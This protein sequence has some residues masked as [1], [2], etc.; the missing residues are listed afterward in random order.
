MNRRSFSL[1]SLLGA[2]FAPAAAAAPGSLGQNLPPASSLDPVVPQVDPAYRAYNQAREAIMAK[3]RLS[4]IGKAPA[5][6]IAH[7]I[8]AQGERLRAQEATQRANIGTNKR[9]IPHN[10]KALR[11]VSKQHKVLMA[12][13]YYAARY[14]NPQR[15]EHLKAWGLQHIF[16]NTARERTPEEIAQ[17]DWESLWIENKRAEYGWHKLEHPSIEGSASPHG[18]RR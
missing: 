8:H 6:F 11:S 13:A 14:A 1:T 7:A 15:P 12:D 10:I 4:T 9:P 17:S 3:V 18:S 16:D 2:I 5:D